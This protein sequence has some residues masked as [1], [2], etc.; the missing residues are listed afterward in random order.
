[1]IINNSTIT[2]NG[3]QG[4]GWTGLV[5]SMLPIWPAI[6]SYSAVYRCFKGVLYGRQTDLSNI[7]H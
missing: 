6:D 2:V 4:E 1:M 5:S 7:F 3:A